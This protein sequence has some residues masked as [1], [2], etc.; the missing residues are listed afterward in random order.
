MDGESPSAAVH[1][2]LGSAL[3]GAGLRPAGF[4]AAGSRATRNTLG[5]GTRSAF[6]LDPSQPY[7]GSKGMPGRRRGAAHPCLAGELAVGIRELVCRLAGGSGVLAGGIS[8]D[9]TGWPVRV[10]DPELREHNG[11]CSCR[12][13]QTDVI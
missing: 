13:S 7:H 11:T 4:V 8:N 6:G 3:G 10:A 12:A 2:R 1:S 5:R 9:A